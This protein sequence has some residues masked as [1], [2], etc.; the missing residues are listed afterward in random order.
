MSR[1][2][3]AIVGILTA[4]L[5][6]RIVL[7]FWHDGS[8]PDIGAFLLVREQFAN[9]PLGFYSVVNA[10]EGSFAWPYLPGYIPVVELV[11]RISEWTGLA[12]GSLIRIPAVIGDLAIAWLVQWHLGWRGASERQRLIACALLAF[13]PVGIAATAAH[14]QIDP[15]QFLPVVL[16]VIAWDRLD[17]DRRYVVAGAL[18]GIGVAI[19]PPAAAAGLALF[20]LAPGVRPR[21][22]VAGAAAVPLG[23][24]CLPYLLAD[25]SGLRTVANYQGVIGHGGLSMLLQPDLALARYAGTTPVAP[26]GAQDVLQSLAGPM[27]VLFGAAAA[28]WIARRR[29]D[30]AVAVAVVLLVMLVLGGNLVPT[31]TLWLLPFAMLAGWTRFVVALQVIVVLVL[32]FKYLPLG[33][34]TS[35]GLA[36]DG[37]FTETAVWVLYIGGGAA[38]WALM[39]WR[40]WAT[41]RSPRVP[42]PV[43]APAVA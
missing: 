1:F 38:L 25:P 40:L 8:L 43:P 6:V 20:A 22:L 35:V 2:T 29:P 15:L 30:P 14:G 34:A 19:K 27:L 21:L 39:A 23:L 11:W 18:V 24:V 17:G 5:A 32:P 37:R 26:T 31:Y 33:V 41:V 9:D 42:A 12:F 4:A 13:A 3:R 7:V 10:T 28:V 36:S 16:A